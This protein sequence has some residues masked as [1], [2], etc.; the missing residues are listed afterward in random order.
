MKTQVLIIDFLK[1]SVGSATLAMSCYLI[2]W[3]KLISYAAVNRWCREE[4]NQKFKK[5]KGMY[6][7]DCGSCSYFTDLAGRMVCT[8]P[9]ADVHLLLHRPNRLE[10]SP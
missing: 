1:C 3:M 4:K 2:T 8:C 10:F 6:F 5:Q 9:F 7:G